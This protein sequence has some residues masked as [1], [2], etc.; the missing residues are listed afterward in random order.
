M[1]NWADRQKARGVKL[2]LTPY[3]ERNCWKKYRDGRVH[4][5]HHPITKQGYDSA[6]LEWSQIVARL[7]AGRANAELYYRLR[8]MFSLVTDWFDHFGVPDGEKPLPRQVELFLKW[9]DG[10]MTIPVLPS[11]VPVQ[12]FVAEH[13]P[14]E[15]VEEFV[16]TQ[17]FEVGGSI[18][19]IRQLP[20]KWEERIRQL[21]ESPRSQKCP[22]TIEYWLDQ[23]V[24]R[25]KARAGPPRRYRR[26]ETGRTRSA[27]SGSLPKQA[28]MSAVS[29]LTRWMHWLA[30]SISRPSNARVGG[31]SVRFECS[32]AGRRNK[33]IAISS[34]RP[35]W[36][37]A[38]SASARR[39]G[40]DAGGWRR[41]S[42]YGRPT[43]F[44]RSCP[45]CPCHSDATAS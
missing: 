19:R 40:E 22:Q 1:A 35:I 20:A 37:T 9:L 23:Y 21:D 12:D 26:R 17:A 3:P 10:Q 14:R 41:G 42:T 34:H 13:H 15:F 25:A 44:G 8:E 7:D 29:R 28:S 30:S 4:Y 43:T 6:L 16:K 31:I 11:E 36:M 27:S 5:L 32:S 38:G 24:T 39:T 33:K 2:H 18:W 45:T